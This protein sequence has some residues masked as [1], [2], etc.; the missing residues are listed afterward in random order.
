MTRRTLQGTVVSTS[1]QKTATVRVDNVKVHPKYHKRYTV[2]KKYF[3]HDEEGKAKVGD[4]VT[5][6]E[7]RPL[8]KNK[9]WVLVSI[10]PTHS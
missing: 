7:I 5:I 8:S 10:E 2:S 3:V 9:R 1:M 4:I 6:K